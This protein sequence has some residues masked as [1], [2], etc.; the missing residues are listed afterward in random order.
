MNMKK[1]KVLLVIFALF[2]CLAK[3]QNEPGNHIHYWQLGI[4]LGEL[5]IG[6]SFKPSFTIGY[7]INEKLYLGI[8]FQ[9]KDQIKRNGSSINAKSSGLDG[10]IS[11]TEVVSPRF[12]FQLRYV[13]VKYGPYLSCG[14]VYNGKD[15]ENMIFDNRE[16]IIASEP[17]TGNIQIQQCRPGGGGLSLGL[18]Y[19][20]NFNNGFSAGFEWTPAW[21]Q[22]PEPEYTITGSTELPTIVKSNLEK[23]MNESFKKS[24]TNLYKIFHIGVAYSFK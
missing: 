11:S 1:V 3:A 7:K 24:V 19:Q 15:T 2:A 8:V 20:Y 13:P 22:C 9:L 23:E 14:Y 12:M 6:G 21:F 17:I 5:P 10:L 18:G 16:R 4:G